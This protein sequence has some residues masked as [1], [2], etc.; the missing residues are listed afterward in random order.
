MTV[1][2][3][4]KI[5]SFEMA[6]ALKGYDGN[7]KSIHGHSYK[8][9]VTVIGKLNQQ[10]GHAKQGML[11][12]FSNLKCIIN[13]CIID[14]YDHA[15]IVNEDSFISDHNDKPLFERMMVF[16]FQPTCENLA[17]HFASIIQKYLPEH[18]S[19]YSLR[20]YETDTSFAEWFMS[21]NIE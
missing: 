2:R 10:K 5:F 4:T 19:L 8:M 13:K 3:I 17:S 21:D 12:D 11:M 1:I 6:H 16:P 20:L 14:V 18:S 15:L 9:H 7:C